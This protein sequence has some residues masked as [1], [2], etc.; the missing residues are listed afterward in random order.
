MEHNCSDIT[1]VDRAGHEWMFVDF[2]VPWDRN[3]MT[4]QGGK[5]TNYSPLAKE[6]RKIHQVSTKIVLLVAGCLGVMSGQ[7]GGT[8]KDL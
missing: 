2:L 4:K 8:L 5:I 1:V 6:I 7:L 3:V